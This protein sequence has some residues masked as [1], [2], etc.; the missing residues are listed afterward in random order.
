MPR[1]VNTTV[2]N[3]FSRGLVTEATGLTFPEDAC[4][5]T[6][7]CEF[8]SIGMVTRRLGFDLE[9]NFA[10]TVQDLQ[11]AVIVVYLWDNVASEGERNFVVVQIGNTLHFYNISTEGSLSE[12][13]HP[14]TINLIDF[15]PSG[16]TTVSTLECQ[17]SSGS[18]LLFVTNPNLDSFYVEFDP[19]GDNITGT[20]I[21]LKIRDFEGDLA[22]ALAVDERPTGTV[23]SLTSAH[24]YNLE[25]QGWTSA[26]LTA[27]DTARTDMPSN[28]DVNWYF[29]NIQLFLELFQFIL[30]YRKILLKLCGVNVE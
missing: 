13:K 30:L 8:D 10:T 7:N 26:N 20:E 5:E 9:E 24:R 27:W 16:I 29:K 1:A 25:N 14:D 4:T 23:G 12:N 11:G 28:A 18:G 22:D 2:Q 15:A 21:T 3:N 6:F 17:F 19:I